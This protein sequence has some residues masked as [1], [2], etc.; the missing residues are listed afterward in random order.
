MADKWIRT[1]R[2]VNSDGT[3]ITYEN[4]E[5]IYTIES[6]KRHIPHAGNRPG[7]WDHTSYFV[8]WEG[9][10]VKELYSL[11]DAKEYAEK[12]MEEK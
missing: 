11:K 3:T 2:R 7:T 4:P 5:S 8:L 10:E 12:Y 1:S 6:R 9:H